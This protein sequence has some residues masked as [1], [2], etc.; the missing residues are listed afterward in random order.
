MSCDFYT[1]SSND[2]PLDIVECALNYIEREKHHTRVAS[3]VYESPTVVISTTAG[4]EPDL[5]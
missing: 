2:G 1:R 3:R 4:G 5:S